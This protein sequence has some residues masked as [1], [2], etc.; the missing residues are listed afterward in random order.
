[1][2]ETIKKLREQLQPGDIK[3]IADKT[4]IAYTTVYKA[5]TGQTTSRK[6]SEIV[7]V[8][9]EILQERKNELKRLENVLN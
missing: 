4:E 7:K 8:T 6:Q 5:L 9:A 3:A 1:M 2:K